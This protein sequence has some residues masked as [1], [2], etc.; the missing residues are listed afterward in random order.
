MKLIPKKRRLV[1]GGKKPG[2]RRGRAKGHKP[3]PP[4]GTGAGSKKTA[5]PGRLRS[6]GL[7][8]TV[9]E[10]RQCVQELAQIR[11]QLG[12]QDLTQKEG[13]SLT[14]VI[15]PWAATVGHTLATLVL[16]YM[17]D[18]VSVTNVD[19]AELAALV[20]ALN[21]MV[22]L[23]LFALDLQG[24][25]GDSWQVVA[26]A[27]RKMAAVLV[28]FIRTALFDPRLPEATRAQMQADAADLLSQFDKLTAQPIQIKKTT[29]KEIK[30]GQAQVAQ[31][32]RRNQLLQTLIALRNGGQPT[33]ADIQQADATYTDL[34]QG[35]EGRTMVPSPMDRRGA[36]R[37]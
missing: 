31:Q 18:V 5:P 8:A 6:D 23:Y 14:L 16:P 25:A 17:S 13:A 29:Q 4:S 10:I 33:V 27:E 11:S 15:D 35:A 26:I 9:E 12:V 21:E 22:D 19:P 28:P 20:D 7:T 37:P 24:Q 36:T 3:A 30:T 34:S 1:G 32:D 2:T